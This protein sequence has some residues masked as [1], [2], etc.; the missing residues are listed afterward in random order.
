M[1][2]DTVKID[3]TELAFQKVY[4][5]AMLKIV[6]NVVRPA[7]FEEP[8]VRCHH[9]PR[10][11]KNIDIAQNAARSWRKA[12]SVVCGPFEQHAIDAGT[13][14]C[15]KCREAFLYDQLGSGPMR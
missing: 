2:D 8:I 11:N 5:K 12:F 7:R 1:K 9:R 4:M 15:I 10:P 3:R 6:T 13:P 14:E